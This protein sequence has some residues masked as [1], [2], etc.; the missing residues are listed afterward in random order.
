MEPNNIPLPPPLAPTPVLPGTGKSKRLLMAVGGVAVIL[1]TIALALSL[2][3]RRT[4]AP[5]TTSAHPSPSAGVIAGWPTYTNTVDFYT[6][7]LPP[8]WVELPHAPTLPHLTQFTSPDGALLQVSAEKTTTTS[9]D[10]YLSSLDSSH[11][12]DWNG[13]PSVKSNKISAAK[14]NTYDGYERAEFW[15]E[16]S[17]QAT[18]TYAK[19]Q[20]EIYTFALIPTGGK[21]A[22]SSQST[23]NDYHTALSTFTLTS[24]AQLGKDWKTY[25]SAAIPSLSYSPFTISYPQTWTA[26]A[27]ASANQLSLAIFR[28]NYEIDI[29][30]A[31][32]GTSVCLFSD[33]PAFNGLSGD[34]RGKQYKEL[35]TNAGLTLRRYFNANAGSTSTMYF[36]EHQ[37]NG[38]YFV[39]PLTI[40]GLVYTVPA[41][42]D[43]DVINEMDNIV[44]TITVTSIASASALSTTPLP[45]SSP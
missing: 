8:G 1:L 10:A 19:V 20:D 12:T 14:V 42:Y 23:V 7:Q 9:L 4:P 37:A 40:G 22:I 25:T 29:S 35:T 17:L 32:V 27:S 44:K 41:Q 6:I 34:L 28:N 5:S 36:C 2:L 38:Q 26:S 43:P 45:T 39:T 13:T 30:Q 16:Q 31:A 21:N 11:Q 24:T 15:A 33:S 3:G 18:V